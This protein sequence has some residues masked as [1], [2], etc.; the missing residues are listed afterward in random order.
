MKPEEIQLKPSSKTGGGRVR[1]FVLPDSKTRITQITTF[2]PDIIG[3][4]PTHLYL[5]EGDAIIL[6]DAGMP[7]HLAKA[8]FYHWRNQPIP[9][10]VDSL[11]PDQSERELLAGLALAGRR[12]EDIDQ[13]V[14]SHGHPDHFLM[15]NSLVRRGIGS[16]PRI[17]WTPPDVQSVGILQGWLSRQDQIVATGMPALWPAG[18]S[19]IEHLY[20]AFDMESLGVALKVDSPIFGD[21][22]LTTRGSLVP[23]I[24]VKQLPGHSAGSIG[25]LVGPPEERALVC[26]DALLNPITP[27]PDNLLVYFRTLDESPRVII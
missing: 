14:I 4:G 18:Q 1:R 23:G 5:I 9:P 13:L 26:G 10:E 24:E 17:F 25:L 2:C 12:V 8:F 19:A 11:A 6:V 7:T 21:G 20:S 3:P 27:I 15:A 16:V 22:P